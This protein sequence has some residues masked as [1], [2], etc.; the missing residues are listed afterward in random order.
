MAEAHLTKTIKKN[1]ST[2]GGAL[3]PEKW[4]GAMVALVNRVGNANFA[5]ISILTHCERLGSRKASRANSSGMNLGPTSSQ[6]MVCPWVDWVLIPRS[7][8]FLI[9]GPVSS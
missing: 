6:A 8:P 9:D 4:G 5:D 3:W 7:T 1:Q 2:W